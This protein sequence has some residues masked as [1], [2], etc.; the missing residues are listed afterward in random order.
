MYSQKLLCY[1]LMFLIFILTEAKQ[2]A[3]W[4][5]NYYLSSCISPSINEDK[6]IIPQER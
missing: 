4:A 5:R 6:L 3:G 1:V 2:V